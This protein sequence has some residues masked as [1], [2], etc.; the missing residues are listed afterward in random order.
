M[1]GVNAMNSWLRPLATRASSDRG[2]VVVLVGL[3]L[4]LGVVFGLLA[5]VIDGGRLLAERRQVQN[6]ADAG[7]LAAA[8]YCAEADAAR[9]AS[10]ASLGSAITSIVNANASDGVTQVTEVCGSASPMSIAAC[11]HSSTAINECQPVDPGLHFA[12]VRTRTATP[13]GTPLLPSFAQLGASGTSELTTQAC[14]QAAWGPANAAWITIP[15]VMPICPA[16]ITGSPIVI[17]DFDPTNPKNTSCSVGGTNY[18]VIDG[19]GFANLDATDKDCRTPVL[20]TVGQIVTVQSS[21]TQLCANLAADMG[22]FLSSGSPLVVP[23]LDSVTGTGQG[24]YEFRI[25]AFKAFTLLGYKIKNLAEG[26]SYPGT[27]ARHWSGTPC[28]SGSQR[29]CLYIV[30]DRDVVPGEIG[31]G[32]NLGVNAID[33]LP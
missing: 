33:L 20:L 3:L 26:G 24:Q 31:P 9:C 4:A 17:A 2:A 11:Q 29:S 5:I 6:G 16:A 7:A 32:V 25:V 22:W 10:S 23:V 15:F 13:G 8:E 18:T 14:A 1:R 28:N 21:A 12:R 30:L 27:P 19:F